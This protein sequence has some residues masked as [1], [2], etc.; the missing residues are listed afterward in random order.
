LRFRSH[1]FPGCNSCNSRLRVRCRRWCGSRRACVG[2]T[3]LATQV[4]QACGTAD[5]WQRVD[6]V[7]YTKCAPVVTHRASAA[8]DRRLGARSFRAFQPDG[9]AQISRFCTLVG[10][11]AAWYGLGCGSG[12]VDLAEISRGQLRGA[13]RSPA[14]RAPVAVAGPRSGLSGCGPARCS[15]GFR[16]WWRVPCAPPRLGL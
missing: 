16:R 15:C 2:Y 11:R 7:S 12:P 5:G 4:R 3:D 8:T 14:D 13:V 9:A 1:N 10:R 6:R